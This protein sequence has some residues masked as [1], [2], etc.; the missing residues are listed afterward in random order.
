VRGIVLDSS[1]N[2]GLSGNNVTNNNYGIEL[3]ISS[4]NFIF[5]NNFVDNTNQVF[6]MFSS[7]NIWDDGSRGNYWS[8]YL[9]KYPN[10]TEIDSSGVW[11]IPYVIDMDNTDHY[12]LMTPYI[13]VHDIAATN[14]T[15]SKTVI[16]RGYILSIN[17]AVANQGGY[18]ENFNATAYANT[19]II[20]AQVVTLTNGNFTTL[21]LTWKTTGFAYGNCTIWAYVEPVPGETNTADNNLTGGTIR[22]TIPGDVKG[23]FNVNLLDAILLS[24]A[25]NSQPNSPNWNGNADIDGNNIV[26]ILDAIILSNHYNQHYP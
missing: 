11:N 15:L 3:S 17:V 14:V 26:N 19:T 23:D 25:Y 6:A 5:Y 21:T 8:D 18:T 20:A 7:V 12:P 24:N 1:S 16:G 13:A 22:V 10:A 9:T 4:D 2:N